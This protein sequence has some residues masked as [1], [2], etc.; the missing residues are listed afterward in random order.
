MDFDLEEDIEF[1]EIPYNKLEKEQLRK[2][3]NEDTEEFIKNGGSIEP[4]ASLPFIP[5]YKQVG[6]FKE[7][8]RGSNRTSF[9]NE[10]L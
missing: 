6:N 2:K 8:M 1:V 10:S 9:N 4:V 7:G 3:L 5:H